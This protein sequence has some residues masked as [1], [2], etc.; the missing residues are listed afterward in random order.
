MF[1]IAL[2]ANLYAQ[3][4]TPPTEDSLV[5]CS[6]VSVPLWDDFVLFSLLTHL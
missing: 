1:F 6:G 3:S 2:D 5:L 4:L